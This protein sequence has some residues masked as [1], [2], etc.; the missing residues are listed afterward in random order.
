MEGKIKWYSRKKGYGFIAGDDGVDYFVHHTELKEEKF[1]RENDKVSF[2]PIEA[3]RGPQAK[4]LVLLQ[5]GSEEELI[6]AKSA[7]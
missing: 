5:K 6:N 1:L 4:K 2:E 3:E 7:Q